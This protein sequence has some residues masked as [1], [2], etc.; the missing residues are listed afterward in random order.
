MEIDFTI[1]GGGI[2]GL[3]NAYQ[4]KKKF[5]DK[6][7]V[8]LE[9][10]SHFGDQ[11]TARNSG[12]L[13]AGLYYPHNSLKKHHCIEGLK[14]WND[15]STELSI[16]IKKCGKFVFCSS[17]DEEKRFYDLLENAKRNGVVGLRAATEKE[18]QTI[19]QYAKIH[20]AFFSSETGI[21]DVPVAVKVFENE[22]FNLGV[23]LLKN[24]K[25]E[26][27]SSKLIIKTNRE[28][29]KAKYLINAAGLGAVDIRR[30]LQ[31]EE[32]SNYF[33][34]GRYL[35]LKKSFYND[36][37]LYPV[38]HK[39]LKGLGVHTSFDF[40]GFVRFGPDTQEVDSLDYSLNGTDFEEMYQSIVAIFPE[41]K[42]EDLSLDYS[43]IRPKIKKEGNLY[44][45]FFI[46]TPRE[47]GIMGYYEF[48]GIESPGLTASPSLAKTLVKLIAEVMG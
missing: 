39:E 10:T 6:E 28:E 14:M 33:V 44:P 35:K 46:G 5:P 16:P 13:H 32:F 48:L 4:I 34:K 38:P 15:L 30:M 11:S 37:L 26:S 27:I 23:H 17:I 36:S 25:V 47:H 8:L 24:N 19:S 43:G 42:K 9:E 2:L 3:I 1:I 7:V 40:E 21:L 29:F 45:D 31:L 20:K 22:C 18:V 41:I 12:V